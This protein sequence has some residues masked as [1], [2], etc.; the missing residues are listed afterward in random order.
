[1]SQMKNV[2]KIK[3]GIKLFLFDYELRVL[4]GVYESVSEGKVDLEPRAFHG[5]YLAQVYIHIHNIY[6]SI[7]IYI[8]VYVYIL[9]G[10]FIYN[11]FFL[12]SGEI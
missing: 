10:L 1:M 4:Y 7:L 11:F 12:V 6:N 9:S 5:K 8:H 3:P 2:E